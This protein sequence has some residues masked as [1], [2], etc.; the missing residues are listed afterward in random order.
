MEKRSDFIPTRLASNSVRLHM[1][2]TFQKSLDFTFYIYRIYVIPI[3]CIFFFA[4]IVNKPQ[5]I[6]NKSVVVFFSSISFYQIIGHKFLESF[7]IICSFLKFTNHL[8]ALA[9]MFS[10]CRWKTKIFFFLW[11][12]MTKEKWFC[13]L[14]QSSD[15]QTIPYF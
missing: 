13:I 3:L 15:K 12:K 2:S 5:Y 1:Q 6:L 9:S 11:L 7:G 4:K 14:S 10:L 8:K